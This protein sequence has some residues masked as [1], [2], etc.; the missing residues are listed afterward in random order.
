MLKRTT[1]LPSHGKLQFSFW[2]P[3]NGVIRGDYRDVM[4]IAP[5]PKQ[6]PGNPHRDVPASGQAVANGAAGAKQRN[7]AATAA[8]GV[9]HASPGSGPMLA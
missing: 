2:D 5:K 1:I 3:V 4:A 8:G 7:A 9:G 6:K